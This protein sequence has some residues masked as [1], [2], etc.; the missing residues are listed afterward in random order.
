MYVYASLFRAPH[1]NVY[2]SNVYQS[3]LYH[4]NF[5]HSNLYHS[6]L[7]HSI[8]R[9]ASFGPRRQ[10]KIPPPG[11]PR[12]GCVRAPVDRQR[13][14]APQ[15]QQNTTR[16]HTRTRRID[17]DNKPTRVCVESNMASPHM[18][19]EVLGT[20]ARCTIWIDR[21]IDRAIDRWI[22]V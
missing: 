14:R 8:M 16:A 15:T 5:Y 9:S 6:N 11:P 13:A 1:S 19:V 2:Q 10:K 22:D 4:S 12:V 17:A 20:G 3:N 18:L 7:Y 21:W